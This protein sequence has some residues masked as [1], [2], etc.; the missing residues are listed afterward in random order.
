MIGQN[1]LGTIFSEMFD[2]GDCY[3]IAPGED[4][5]EEGKNEG[6]R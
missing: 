5:A 3:I 6:H 1:H 2:P 4:E